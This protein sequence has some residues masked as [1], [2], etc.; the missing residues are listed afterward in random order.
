MAVDRFSFTMDAELGSAV[1][2]SAARANMS[3]SAWLA[4]AAADRLRNDLLGRA[5][6]RWEAE[7][8]ALSDDELDV[9]AAK[10]GIDRRPRAPSR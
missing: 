4:E 9:A 3:V 7:D 2:E 10:L 5:L 8:G 6:D 1:R